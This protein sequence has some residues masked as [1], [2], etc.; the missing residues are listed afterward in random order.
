[1]ATRF[2]EQGEKPRCHSH[3]ISDSLTQWPPI[4]QTNSTSTLLLLQRPP[5]RLKE[6][7][8]EPTDEASDQPSVTTVNSDTKYSTGLDF[9]LELRFWS[10]TTHLWLHSI[11][12]S[13]IMVLGE[14]YQEVLDTG[15]CCL[16]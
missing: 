2:K 6:G 4:H 8:K 1:M 13:T 12:V 10:S 11:T 16:C 5:D 14:A 9:G 7:E 15:V 3:A